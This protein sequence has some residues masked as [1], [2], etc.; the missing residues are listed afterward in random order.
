MIIVLILSLFMNKSLH[1]I[2]YVAELKSSLA[3]FNTINNTSAQNQC[4]DPK[5]K[6]S[7]GCRKRYES[8]FRD[9]VLNISVGFGYF[10][11]EAPSPVVH[12]VYMRFAFVE[13]ITKKP[14]PPKIS[15]CGFQ[16]SPDDADKFFKEIINPWG[17][18]HRVE[19]SLTTGALS[20]N[21][22]FNT[23]ASNINRQLK[24]CEEATQRFMNHVKKGDEV[25]L[26]VGHSRDGGAPDFC[27][28][29]LLKNGRRD[30]PFYRSQRPGHKRMMAALEEA[31]ALGKSSEIIGML[32]CNTLKHYLNPYTEKANKTGLILSNNET[33]SQDQ[34]RNL[35]G[36]IDSVLAQRCEEGFAQSVKHSGFMSLKNVFPREMK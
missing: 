13:M 21:N 29:K 30:Y 35:F 25:V 36:S 17:K 18:K 5:S 9:P 2:D 20:N 15:A 3:Q 14:C 10:D 11:H 19:L 8:M 1:A 34:L 24:F 27:P 16:R 22:S 7:K 12:D 28:P 23:N 32:S 26:Y 6:I 31:K 4:N 33:L